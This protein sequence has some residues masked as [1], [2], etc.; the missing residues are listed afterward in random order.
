MHIPDG[1]IPLA[2]ATIYW[3]VSIIFLLIISFKLS[4]DKMFNKQV[5]LTAVLTAATVVATSVSI[6]SP[7]G[8]PMHFFLIPL[9]V[10]ILGLYKGSLV[11]FLSLVFQSIFLGMGGITTLGANFLVMGIILSLC[12]YFVYNLFLDVN[13]SVAIFLS[14]LIGIMGATFAQIFILMLTNTT[15]F[16]VLLASLLPFYLVVGILEGLINIFILG[17]IKRVRPEILGL[18]ADT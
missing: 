16:N 10:M 13:N 14:T 11:S 17:F 9:V 7:M 8:I 5:V 4:K 6:P 15:S 12:V 3:V 1:I 2:Q 18:S